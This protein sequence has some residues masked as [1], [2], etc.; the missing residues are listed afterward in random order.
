MEFNELLYSSFLFSSLP[1]EIVDSIAD[2]RPLSVISLQRGESAPGAEC[3]GGIGFVMS[4]RLEVRRLR[5][6]G[7][8]V[9]LNQLREGDSF[10]VL[11]VFS[12]EEAPTAVVAKVGSTIV[13]IHR[14]EVLT[15]MELY[16]EIS[17]NI[18]YFMADRINFLNKKIATFSG[19]RAQDR[20][21]SYLRATA[22]VLGKSSF[23][24]NCK[25]CSEAINAGRASVYR[26]IETL[27]SEG[28]ITFENK[29]VTLINN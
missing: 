10:G 1:R 11:S 18:I 13:Y 5:E 25:H 2:N 23:P 9:A 4:G 14:D 17:K 29:T 21:L 28:V 8:T 24:L 3:G 12:P 15:L 16:P 22:E 26:A 27:V 6:D 20:L 7:T 19:T